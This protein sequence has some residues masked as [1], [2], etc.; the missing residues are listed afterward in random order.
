MDGD[1]AEKRLMELEL[2][3]FGAGRF[4]VSE[5]ASRSAAHRH[6]LPVHHGRANAGI[7]HRRG[8]DLKALN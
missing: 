3:A 1:A 7:A 4:A 5:S 2:L 6:G 8:L